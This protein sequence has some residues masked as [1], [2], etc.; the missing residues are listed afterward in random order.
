MA[1]ETTKKTANTENDLYELVPYK[2]P[3]AER[4]DAD[5]NF[6]V[7]V[8]GKAYIMPRGKESMIPRYVYNEIMRAEEAAEI[9]A[10]HEAEMAE[11]ARQ[12]TNLN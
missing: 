11:K 5:P 8:N 6:Y 1:T 9:M 3:R 2:P 12:G 7:S 10:E 4:S